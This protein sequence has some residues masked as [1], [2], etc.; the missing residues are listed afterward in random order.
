[1]WRGECLLGML[2]PK[3]CNPRNGGEASGPARLIDI[4]NGGRSVGIV[5]RKRREGAERGAARPHSRC[6]QKPRRRTPR[7][8][9]RGDANRRCLY[10]WGGDPR[11]NEVGHPRGLPCAP[12]LRSCTAD[13]VRQ[14]SPL[15]CAGKAP[16]GHVTVDL[17]HWRRRPRG[18]D[19]T[20]E[21]FPRTGGTLFAPS[22]GA[23]RELLDEG[24]V[25]AHVGDLEGDEEY[26]LK[27]GRFRFRPLLWYDDR[28]EDEAGAFQRLKDRWTVLSI[29]LASRAEVSARNPECTV[30]ESAALEEKHL[31]NCFQYAA[32]SQDTPY[33]QQCR[34]KLWGLLRASHPQR[35]GLEFRL[36][37]DCAS[38]T[39]ALDFGYGGTLGV[40]ASG[41][42]RGAEG[43]V[44]WDVSGSLIEEWPGEPL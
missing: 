42:E 24:A 39:R 14:S 5:R 9:R 37:D 31:R 12:A 36:G 26:I 7:S 30:Q 28:A 43:V 17:F 8:A 16:D 44:L 10:H 19:W 32:L 29:M 38:G 22:L 23:A 41:E 35:G 1:M 27:R 25:R 13:A 34:R 20:F 11:G 3:A 18:G 2:E 33:V 4:F 40:V 21:G 6:V 15:L